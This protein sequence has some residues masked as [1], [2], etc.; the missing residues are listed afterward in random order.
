[1][2]GRGVLGREGNQQGAEQGPGCQPRSWGSLL[3]LAPPCDVIPV[4]PTSVWRSLLVPPSGMDST[5]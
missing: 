4:M 2:R 1:M 5:N 3:L